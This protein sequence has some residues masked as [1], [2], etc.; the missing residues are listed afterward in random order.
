MSGQTPNNFVELFRTF[1]TIS[2]DLGLQRQLIT[3]LEEA[4][5]SGLLSRLRRD[6]SSLRLDD[7]GLTGR[8][9]ETFFNQDIISDTAIYDTNSL[10]LH[11]FGL[12]R[13]KGFPLHDHPN[14]IGLSVLLFGQVTYRNLSIVSVEREKIFTKQVISDSLVAPGCLILTP[15]FGNIHEIYAV[16]NSV[17]LDIFVPNY[18]STNCCNFY[19]QDSQSEDNVVLHTIKPPDLRARP[20]AYRGPRIT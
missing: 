19:L 16:E 14:M 9:F 13:G 8:Y 7:F 12:P 20:L 2:E 10:S 6:I 3:E 1:Q 5:E 11:L 18:S 17:V 15:S 4:N